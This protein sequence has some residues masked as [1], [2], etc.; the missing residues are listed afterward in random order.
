M[1]NMPVDAFTMNPV[2]RY[3][4]GQ[5]YAG[6]LA[7]MEV[8][9][10]ANLFRPRWF[11]IPDDFNQPLTPY[12][13][14]EYQIKVGPASYL[15]GYRFVQ[16]NADWGEVEPA[17]VFLQMTDS[18]TGIPL[19]SEFVGGKSAAL[20]Q[21]APQN[22]GSQV[23]YLLTQPRLILEPGLVNVELS[24]TSA[25]DVSCQLL[26]LFAEPC[27]MVDERGNRRAL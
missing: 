11:V 13:T 26:V 7:Q 6:A 19:L 4:P 5:F 15:W 3:Y 14:L 20:Y 23:P 1:L 9:R 24:S 18:C 12:G 17:N 10:R 21:T 22:R 8:L 2:T 16:V 25:E 27:S